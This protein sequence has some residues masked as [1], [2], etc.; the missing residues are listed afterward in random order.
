MCNLIKS[1]FVLACWQRPTHALNLPKFEWI[2][3]ALTLILNTA[4]IFNEI[5]PTRFWVWAKFRALILTML[6]TITLMSCIDQ[7]NK[8]HKEMKQPIF[9]ASTSFPH[10]FAVHLVVWSAYRPYAVAV[11]NSFDTWHV[12][13]CQ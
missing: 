11:Q 4:S 3:S 5:R 6:T 8:I 12:E 7:P 13:E 9:N 1:A 2:Y 10:G